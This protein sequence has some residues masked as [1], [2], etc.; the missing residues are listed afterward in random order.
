MPS[1]NGLNTSNLLIW[2]PKR[3][4]NTKQLKRLMTT[5][6]YAKSH[7]VSVPAVK[8]QIKYGKVWATK[9]GNR[10]WIDPTPE[11]P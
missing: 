1:Q 9:I 6:D 7:Q 3:V 5:Q 10:V 2:K 4:R 11:I 8:Y